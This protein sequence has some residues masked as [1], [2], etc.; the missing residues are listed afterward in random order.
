MREVVY[1]KHAIRT[2]NRMPANEARRIR[3]KVLQYAE[4]PA[5]LANNVKKLK[6]S[7]YHLLRIGDWRV[8]FGEDGTVVD[9]IRVAAR[10]EAYE[11]EL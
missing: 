7:R 1:S 11:G 8:I 2:L 9:V 10:G 4:D 6:D 5:S 3:S